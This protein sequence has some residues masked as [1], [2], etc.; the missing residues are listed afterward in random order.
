MTSRATT[1]TPSTANIIT[2]PNWINEKCHTQSIFTCNICCEISL[3]PVETPCDHIFCRTCIHQSL[4]RNR[5]CPNDRTPLRA[6]QLK[7]LRGTSKRIW[8]QTPVQCPEC[9]TWTGSIQSYITEHGVSCVNPQKRIKELEGKLKEAEAELRTK[10]NQMQTQIQALEKQL[11]TALEEQKKSALQTSGSMPQAQM[12]DDNQN[13]AKRSGEHL[14][15]R[16]HYTSAT[17]PFGP[18]GTQH[19]QQQ[20]NNIAFGQSSTILTAPNNT[21]TLGMNTAATAVAA[22]IVS[23]WNYQSTHGGVDVQFQIGVARHQTRRIIRAKR[24][25][26]HI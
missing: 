11:N 13:L 20:A 25:T 6:S 4:H 15:T 10:T 5:F 24:P 19:Q 12:I 21:P 26:P 9:Q 23:N 17:G 1:Q 2:P 22:P 16:C 18:F 14:Q 8:S 3:D 7:E